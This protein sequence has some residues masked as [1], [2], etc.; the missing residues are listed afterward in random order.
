MKSTYTLAIVTATILVTWLISGQ[1]QAPEDS[2]EA[3]T[4]DSTVGVITRVQTRISHAAPYTVQIRASGQT[5]AKRSVQVRAESSGRVVALPVEKGL[6]V[7]EGKLLCKLALDDRQIKLEEASSQL[8][9]ARLEHQGLTTLSQ[10]GFQGEVQIAAAEVSLINAKANLKFQE[11]NLA[12]RNINAPFAGVVQER[13]VN[14]GDF[15]QQGQVCAEVLDPNPMLIVAHVTQQELGKLTLAGQAEVSIG[16]GAALNGTVS[17][18]SHAADPITRTYR[19]EVEVVNADYAIRDGLSAEI[20]LNQGTVMAH[21]VS[22]ASLSLSDTGAIGAK[23]VDNEDV[24]RFVEVQIVSD[25]ATGVWLTGLP[26]NAELITVGQELVFAGQQVIAVPIGAP[27]D[28]TV[29]GG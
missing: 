10:Q 1:I 20:I 18:V 28:V 5:Q 16:H 29:V 11:L 24:V 2:D 14:I 6:R 15:L 27:F 19:I 9:H 13:P 26:P 7:D 22:P 23:I 12:R 8:R 4:E 21:N 25:T 17:F 3:K